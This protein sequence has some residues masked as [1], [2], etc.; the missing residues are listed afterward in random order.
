MPQDCSK[1]NNKAL[2]EIFSGWNLHNLIFAHFFINTPR[3]DGTV[4]G[5][6]S[7]SSH[8]LHNYTT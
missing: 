1:Q 6:V 8:N 5:G 7:Q 2:Q 4:S 3:G